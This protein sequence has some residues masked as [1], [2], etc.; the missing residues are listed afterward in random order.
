MTRLLLKY[1][2][3]HVILLAAFLTISHH[4]LQNSSRLFGI[5]LIF[6]IFWYLLF[7]CVLVYSFTRYD[8]LAFHLLYSYLD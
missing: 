2:Y 7:C 6:L 8:T 1:M 5:F 3:V 4:I